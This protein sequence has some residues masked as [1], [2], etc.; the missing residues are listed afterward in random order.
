MVAVESQPASRTLEGKP[1]VHF[2]IVCRRMP[3]HASGGPSV[4]WNR[5]IRGVIACRRGNWSRRDGLRLHLVSAISKIIKERLTVEGLSRRVRSVECVVYAVFVPE[6][7]GPADGH[8]R[9]A[10]SSCDCN[11]RLEANLRDG[12]VSR[13]CAREVARVP[14]PR[15]SLIRHP[16]RWQHRRR[17]GGKEERSVTR[18]VTN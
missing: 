13:A 14:A 2:R 8:D 17:G 18:V 12:P 6:G 11:R 5:R 1:Y 4:A 16:M 15:V 3:A 9:G 10:R 7:L